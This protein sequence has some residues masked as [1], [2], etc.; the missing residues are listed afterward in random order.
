LKKLKNLNI[1][2]HPTSQIKD[3]LVENL[4][5]EGSKQFITPG[6]AGGKDTNAVK[7]GPERAK[8]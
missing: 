2:Y 6:V 1:R 4:R 5:S 3:L 7:K 8:L